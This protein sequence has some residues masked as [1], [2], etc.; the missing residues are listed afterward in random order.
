M[1][2]YIVR[3]DIIP[4]QQPESYVGWIESAVRRT[5]AV[6]GVK[7]LAAYRPVAGQSQV[8]VSFTFTDFDSWSTWFN[9]E[10]VQTVFGELFDLAN[11]VQRE[12]WEPSPILPR[13]ITP[14]TSE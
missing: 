10:Q 1:L 9:D 12:L 14:E 6:P 3:W 13:P 4:T 11:N 2:R 5:L 7:E 8:V